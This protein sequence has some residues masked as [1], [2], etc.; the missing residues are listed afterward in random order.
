MSQ[1]ATP[2]ASR[3]S[4]SARRAILAAA[5]DLVGK[6]GYAK[7]SIEGIATAAGVGKQTIYR[8]WPSKGALLF[9]AFLTLT[10]DGQDD[11][12]GGLPDTGDLAADLKLVL[13]A[14]VDELND[15][16][17]DL[18]MRALHTEIV[19]DPT[20]AA[21][22]AKR[23][24]EPVRVVKKNRLRAAQRAGQLAE[25]VDLDVAIDMLFG[26]VLNRWLQRTGPLTHEYTDQVV[27]TAL[28]G[29]QPRM[30]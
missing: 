13:R 4:D 8:W 2:D 14:T 27:D 5:L 25:G 28:R 24:D 7:L 22:Y 26:P 1:K 6:V 9:D 23:L 19:L 12:P 10:T 11:Q 20:L 15:P 29:L 16:R 30:P 17:F 21:D 3:R 18:P